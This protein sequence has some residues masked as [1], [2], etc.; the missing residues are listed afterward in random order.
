MYRLVASSFSSFF[1]KAN[2]DVQYLGLTS[3]TGDRVGLYLEGH[4]SFAVAE[5]KQAKVGAAMAQNVSLRAEME[6][7]STQSGDLVNNSRTAYFVLRPAMSYRAPRMS[8]VAKARYMAVTTYRV[9]PGRVPDWNDYVK[10][11]N[12]AREK[13]GDRGGLDG[14]GLGVAGVSDGLK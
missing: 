5:Q 14:S 8:D 11:L 1:A 7:M 3:I 9:K 10:S 6:R 12:A 13:A 4:P 2:P